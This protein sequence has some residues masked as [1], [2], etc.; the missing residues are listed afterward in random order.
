[1]FLI[2]AIKGKSIKHPPL[3]SSLPVPM[4]R[5][6]LVFLVTVSFWLV[7]SGLKW[8][9]SV[10]SRQLPSGHP[11]PRPDPAGTCVLPAC[12]ASLPRLAGCGLRLGAP[13]PAPTC[14]PSAGHRG[15]APWGARLLPVALGAQSP[16][17]NGTGG[18]PA[19]CHVGWAGC[20]ECHPRAR[21]L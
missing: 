1:M 18:H 3:P 4:G 8:W 5:V 9:E 13:A 10:L 16:L 12:A 20:P 6:S 2:T 17:Q 7:T 19:C 15:P 14:P 21:R 11:S